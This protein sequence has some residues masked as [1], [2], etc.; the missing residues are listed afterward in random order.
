MREAY[1]SK[2]LASRSQ[3][4]QNVEGVEQMDFIPLALVTTSSLQGQNPENQAG[5][6]QKGQFPAA[7]CYLIYLTFQKPCQVKKYTFRYIR[8]GRTG[9]EPAVVKLTVCSLTTWPPPHIEK[10]PTSIKLFVKQ[11]WG[12]SIQ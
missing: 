1:K 8:A 12:N 11:N 7:N 2:T 4:G 5:I 10:N 3:R 6:I 9:F